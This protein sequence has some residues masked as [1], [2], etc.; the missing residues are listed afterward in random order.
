[1]VPNS[2]YRLHHYI[3]LIV[4]FELKLSSFL[5]LTFEA[6]AYAVDLELVEEAGKREE[7]DL[8]LVMPLKS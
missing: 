1:M 3:L 5:I 2:F 4:S 8:K 6:H 7:D